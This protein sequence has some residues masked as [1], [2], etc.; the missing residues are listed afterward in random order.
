MLNSR[1]AAHLPADGRC[2]S[3][4]QSHSRSGKTD[5]RQIILHTLKSVF[6]E[7]ALQRYVRFDKKTQLLT[8]AGRK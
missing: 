6:P 7:V 5:A 1:G 8:V 2:G 4:D 3:E